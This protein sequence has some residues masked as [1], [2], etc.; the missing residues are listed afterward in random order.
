MKILIFSAIDGYWGGSEE[1]WFDM[2]KTA[3]ETSEFFIS[4]S[5]DLKLPLQRLLTDVQYSLRFF[6][7]K[8]FASVDG[9]SRKVFFVKLLLKF[10]Q[11]NEIRRHLAKIKKIN[12]DIVVFNLSDSYSH[13]M[14]RHMKEYVEQIDRPYV[15]VVQLQTPYL[16]IDQ[17]TRGAALKTFQEAK[18]IIFVSEQNRLD[19]ERELAVNLPNSV[20]M[21]NP[22]GFKVEIDSHAYADFSETTRCRFAFVARFDVVHKGQD[23]VLETLS[24]PQWKDRDWELN[25]YGNGPDLEHIKKLIKFFN[26]ESRTNF[27]GFVRDA[28]EIWKENHVLLMPSRK[29]GLPIVLLEALVCARVVVVT[30]VGGNSEWVKDEETGFI[31]AAPT[32]KSFSDAI[33][34]AWKRRDGWRDIGQKAYRETINRIDHNP[35]ASL[36]KL[37]NSVSKGN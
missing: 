20:V 11:K 18:K 32:K 13:L 34:R 36:F 33:E 7:R 27:K 8:E 23:I 12:P 5:A 3:P 1:L 24:Q 2:I 37:L 15:I 14:N 6:P 19:T 10:W 16:R 29:E 30:D 17:K 28:R 4:H 21:Q 35:G 31:A 9:W 22:I 26:L 25:F